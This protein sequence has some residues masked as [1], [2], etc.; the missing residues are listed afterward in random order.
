MIFNPSFKTN[1]SDTIFTSASLSSILPD[2][3]RFEFSS[4]DV[5]LKLV[6]VFSKPISPDIFEIFIPSILTVAL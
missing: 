3:E 2:I 1:L 5:K 4:F 6:S